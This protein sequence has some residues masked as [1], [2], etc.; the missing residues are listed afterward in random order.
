MGKG[1][2][3]TI[4]ALIRRHRQEDSNQSAHALAAA[5]T[6]ASLGTDFGIVTIP[7]IGSKLTLVDPWTFTLFGESRNRDLWKK[8]HNDEPEESDMVRVPDTSRFGWRWGYI[9]EERSTTFPAGTVLRVDRIYIRSNDKDKEFDSITF[10]IESMPGVEG[11]RRAFT[12]GGTKTVGRFWAK[13]FDVN[14]I[15]C[16]WDH[17]SVPRD[18]PQ[19]AKAA[20]KP[21]P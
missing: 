21:Q 12:K 10:I 15:V 14:R 17:P 8:L 13:L 7:T 19:P 9:H 18:A 3:E 20:K 1:S 11:T 4:R 2:D 6:R 5:V 16:E